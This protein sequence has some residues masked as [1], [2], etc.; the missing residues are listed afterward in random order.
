MLGVPGPLLCCSDSP[1]A[2]L[3]VRAGSSHP[4]WDFGKGLQEAE[5]GCKAGVMRMEQMGFVHHLGLLVALLAHG[6]IARRQV[7]LGAAWSFSHLGKS[8]SR[9]LGPR[10]MSAPR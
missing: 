4:Q 3:W 1:K 9:S 8:W 7:G 10:A 2:M 5:S 6:H